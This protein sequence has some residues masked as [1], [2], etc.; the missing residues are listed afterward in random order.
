MVWFQ[1][2]L[3]TYCF[4]WENKYKV[5]RI[6]KAWGEKILNSWTDYN[7][8]LISIMVIKKLSLLVTELIRIVGF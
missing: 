7:S 4:L 3:I 5:I 2:I 1:Q 6:A 8:F